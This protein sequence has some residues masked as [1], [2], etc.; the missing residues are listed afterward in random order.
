MLRLWKGYCFGKFNSIFYGNFC[1]KINRFPI[2]G[3]RGLKYY[4]TVFVHYIPTFYLENWK[5]LGTYELGSIS[6]KGGGGLLALGLKSR[7]IRAPPRS[8]DAYSI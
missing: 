6:F 2:G 7:S 4:V 5:F 3:G 1:L 8:E